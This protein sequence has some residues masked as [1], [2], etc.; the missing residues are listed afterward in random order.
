M[1]HFQDGT[2]DP[3]K[4]RG[5]FVA[6][7]LSEDR[8]WLGAFL[9]PERFECSYVGLEERVDSTQKR[10][11]WKKWRQFFRLALTARRELARHPQD[12]IVTAFPQVGFTVGLGE[13]ADLRAHPARHLVLQ[14][15]S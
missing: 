13:P 12:L 1:N 4:V 8:R 6:W 7:F 15:R 10:T 5:L 11:P 3:A 14:L 9:P 2:K